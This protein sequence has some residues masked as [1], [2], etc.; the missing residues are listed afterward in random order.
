MKNLWI[1]ILILV[2]LFSMAWLM[3]SIATLNRKIEYLNSRDSRDT[4]EFITGTTTS[5]YGT[6]SG[7]RGVDRIHVYSQLVLLTICNELFGL[8]EEQI[9]TQV[10]S[11]LRLAGINAI[12]GDNMIL[13]NEPCLYLEINP[14][15]ITDI[16]YVF[17][18][19]CRLALHRSVVLPNNMKTDRHVTA[20]TWA[21]SWF[22]S[23]NT[24]D[25]KD[26][27]TKTINELVDSF[28]KDYIEASTG[29]G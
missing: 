18:M 9:K 16:D 1:A 7:L 10:V 8:S 19:N 17:T 28:I 4:L 29:K 21:A 11:K 3:K 6:I 14:I 12:S 2:V 26:Q 13:P 24:I 25:A 23:V 22:G 27:C 5:K 20:L 15:G